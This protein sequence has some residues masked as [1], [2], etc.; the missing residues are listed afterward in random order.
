MLINISLNLNSILAINEPSQVIFAKIIEIFFWKLRLKHFK[1]WLVSSLTKIYFQEISLE[2]TIRLSWYDERVK[3]RNTS[4]NENKNLGYI[5]LNRDPVELF[6]FPDM[7]IDKAKA[8][9]KPSYEIP[10]SSLRIYP[11]GLFIYS[12]RVNYDISCPMDF[13]F[14][15]VRYRLKFVG[16]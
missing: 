5:I 6:W 3:A 2:S 12:A 15:P 10:P 13:K 1:Y 11:S 4:T 16:V 9:R 14:Y 7:Y 8:I